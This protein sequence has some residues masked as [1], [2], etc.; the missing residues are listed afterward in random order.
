MECVDDEIDFVIAYGQKNWIC[1]NF[2]Y[3]TTSRD[4]QNNNWPKTYETLGIQ[5][6][7]PRSWSFI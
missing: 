5:Q 2:W 6:A 7:R 1:W 3:D 4:H